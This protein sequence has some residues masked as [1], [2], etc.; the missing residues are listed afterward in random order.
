MV[1]ENV[2]YQL[3]VNWDQRLASLLPQ[4]GFESIIFC[5]YEN[6]QANLNILMQSGFQLL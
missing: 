6:Y 5:S 4:P 3:W 2:T 1:A